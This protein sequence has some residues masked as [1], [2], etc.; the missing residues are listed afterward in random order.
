MLGSRR[1][2]GHSIQRPPKLCTVCRKPLTSMQAKIK[3]SEKEARKDEVCQCE[4]CLHNRIE[5][6]REPSVCAECKDEEPKS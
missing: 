2:G 6:S 1:M 4:R 3:W 5:G